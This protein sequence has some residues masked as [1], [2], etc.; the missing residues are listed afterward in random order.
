MEFVISSD[1]NSTYLK[2]KIIQHLLQNGHQIKDLSESIDHSSQDFNFDLFHQFSLS[3]QS[4]EFKQGILLTENGIDAALYANKHCGI[5]CAVCNETYGAKVAKEQMAANV[6]SIG[7]HIVGVSTAL[8]IIDSWLYTSFDRIH[9]LKFIEKISEIELGELTEPLL[10]EDAIHYKPL[11]TFSPST[12]IKNVE[13]VERPKEPIAKAS[14]ESPILSSKSAPK[15]DEPVS[16]PTPKPTTPPEP[17]L[18]TSSDQMALEGEKPNSSS[19]EDDPAFLLAD[20]P[21]N[22][23]G[24]PTPPGPPVFVIEEDLPTPEETAAAYAEMESAEALSKKHKV[25]DFYE[26]K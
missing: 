23:T 13:K 14:L 2:N 25:N 18:E 8:E 20:P 12:P 24:L 7:S 19:T 4:G 9:H 15:V 1:F 3:I 22:S 11:P 26:K 10:Q 21:K 6:I 5:R 16:L 17:V